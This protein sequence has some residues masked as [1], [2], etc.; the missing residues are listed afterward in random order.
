[1]RLPTAALLYVAVGAGLLACA[2]GTDPSATPSLR[3]VGSNELRAPADFEAI[4]DRDARTRALFVA[5]ARVL[6][7]PR[8]VNC[9]PSGDIPHQGMKLELH[10]P[11]V[12]RGPGGQG[13][14]GM[15]CTSCHQDR[16][17]ALARVPGA[18]KWA[19]APIEMAW[20]GK[21]LRHIC[22]QIQDPE[23]NGGKTLAE[24]VEHS[25]RDPLVAWGWDPGAGREPAPGS[26]EQ[27]GALVG[28]W[29]ETGAAC[30]PEEEK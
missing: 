16:N 13:V 28:A 10:D 26:Q 5:A 21:S 12:L 18:P 1:M 11:P 19:L 4:T 27:F 30:P 7:H 23:R 22:S 14:V 8:C 3:S 9:H 17:Q 2:S 24:I 29:V 6:H 20:V 15:E 25:T